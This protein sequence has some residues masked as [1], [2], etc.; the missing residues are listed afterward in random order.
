MATFAVQALNH[1]VQDTHTS[2]YIGLRQRRT[3]TSFHVSQK[4][5]YTPT[6]SGRCATVGM[7]LCACDP[8]DSRWFMA[9]PSLYPTQ[10][11]GASL[12]L[13]MPKPLPQAPVAA[14][15]SVLLPPPPAVPPPEPLR[16][17]RTSVACRSKYPSW[18][19]LP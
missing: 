16:A 2:W 19:T 12:K 9:P 10:G 11:L 17:A 7:G 3:A 1:T 18:G 5:L 15:P 14:A 8:T 6:A 13:T 4:E